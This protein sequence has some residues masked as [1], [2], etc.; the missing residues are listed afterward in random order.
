MSE[1]ITAMLI[2][3]C[4]CE[5]AVRTSGWEWTSTEVEISACSRYAAKGIR[6]FTMRKSDA[7]NLRSAKQQSSYQHR[8]GL[9][10]IA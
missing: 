6:S 9:V 5:E 2:C 1:Q 4:G 10:V 8:D 3:P 7:L